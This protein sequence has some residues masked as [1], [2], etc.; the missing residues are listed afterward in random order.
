MEKKFTPRE[1]DHELLLSYWDSEIKMLFKK[2]L[3]NYKEVFMVIQSQG[4]PNF[5]KVNQSIEEL[6]RLVIDSPKGVPLILYRICEE[7]D[8]VYNYA[9]CTALLAGYLSYEGKYSI[10]EAIRV[11]KAGLL[12]NI[13]LAKIKGDILRSK[14]K[15]SHAEMKEWNKHILYGYQIVSDVFGIDLFTKNI[16]IQ[17]EELLDGT[18]MAL[19]LKSDKICMGARFVGIAE[20]YYRYMCPNHFFNRKTPFEILYNMQEEGISKYDQVIVDIFAQSFKAAFLGAPVRLSDGNTGYITEMKSFTSMTVTLNETDK[21]VYVTRG[22]K[23][24][25]ESIL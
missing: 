12:S 15:F 1:I 18:G 20:M 21:E 11:C 17:H 8:Y 9:I 13:G 6:F 14:R 23:L 19:K 25:I 7:D 3:L 24:Q 2:V 22:G 10:G 5:K 16:V 4:I